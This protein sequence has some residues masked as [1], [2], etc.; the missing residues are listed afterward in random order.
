MALLSYIEHLLWEIRRGT[1][2]LFGTVFY[3]NENFL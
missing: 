2:S 1:I 3:K